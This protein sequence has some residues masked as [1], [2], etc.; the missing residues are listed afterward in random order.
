MTVEEAIKGLKSMLEH[1]NLTVYEQRL[2][3]KVLE[4]L[5]MVYD[6]ATEE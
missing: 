6:I 2:L 1:N 3:T 5:Q 4:V